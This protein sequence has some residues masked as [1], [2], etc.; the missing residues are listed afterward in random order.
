MNHPSRYDA[1]QWAMMNSPEGQ[2]RIRDG[3][4]KYLR[5]FLDTAPEDK[6]LERVQELLALLK[7]YFEDEIIEL[8]GG[9][10][11]D[12]ERI[13]RTG[14]MALVVTAVETAMVMVPTDETRREHF[15]AVVREFKT[16]S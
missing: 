15:D 9:N 3:L 4:Y 13:E 16:R 12:L 10:P 6:P 5:S 8:E 14:S 2:K 11:D 7:R 1:E